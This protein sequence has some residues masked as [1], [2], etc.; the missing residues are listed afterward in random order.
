[1]GGVPSLQILCFEALTR[2]ERE[3]LPKE[4]VESVLATH[5]P[6]IER[7]FRIDFDVKDK[8]T[9]VNLM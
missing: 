1:M 3:S 2:E 7:M 9:N 8:S 5:T 4:L 6:T